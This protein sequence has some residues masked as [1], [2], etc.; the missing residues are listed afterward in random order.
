ML[1]L[2]AIG[3]HIPTNEDVNDAIDVILRIQLVYNK[4]VA[5]VRRAISLHT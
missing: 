4:S 1:D 2:L 3:S 5:E